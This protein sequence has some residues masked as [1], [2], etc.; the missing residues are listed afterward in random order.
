MS[1]I[2]SENLQEILE[3]LK[4]S[5]SKWIV[6]KQGIYTCRR[7]YLTPLAKILYRIAGDFILQQRVKES[8]DPERSNQCS[9][10]K[11][12]IRQN[13]RNQQSNLTSQLQ[14]SGLNRLARSSR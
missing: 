12:L 2:E 10:L 11:Y 5:D 8:E 6:S 13:Q 1:N 9:Q 3:E 4:V 7:E 14:C